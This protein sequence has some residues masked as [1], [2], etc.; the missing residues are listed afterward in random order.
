MGYQFLPP[1][2]TQGNQPIPKAPAVHFAHLEEED[3][4]INED[5]KSNDASGIEGVMKEFMVCLVRAVKD[6][7][8]EDKCCYHSSSPKHFIC[9][10]TLIETLMENTQLN[11][12]EGMPLRK[13]AWTPLTTANA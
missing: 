3:A 12:K 5:E 6:A 13:G 11:G 9:N 7:Q 10:C 2:E 1:A 4:G 8:M